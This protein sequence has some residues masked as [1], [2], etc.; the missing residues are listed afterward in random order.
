M[1]FDVIRSDHDFG[2]SARF[3]LGLNFIMVFIA[4]ER[5]IHLC[6]KA[7]DQHA[8]SVEECACNDF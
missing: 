8:V 6:D 5:G 1:T 4:T 7:D 3:E 2:V